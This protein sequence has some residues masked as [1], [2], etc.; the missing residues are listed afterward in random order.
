MGIQEKE[1]KLLHYPES[2][3][4]FIPEVLDTSSNQ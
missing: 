1:V 3:L 4:S 2:S